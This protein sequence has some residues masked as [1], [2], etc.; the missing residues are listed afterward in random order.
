MENEIE[1]ISVALDEAMEAIYARIGWRSLPW[2]E[3]Q[4]LSETLRSMFD[5]QLRLTFASVDQVSG[6]SAELVSALREATTAAR[7]RADKINNTRRA[8]EKAGTVVTTIIDL[9]PFVGR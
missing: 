5:A 7:S 3:R 2:E 1:Q 4:K 8:I 9:V 6:S